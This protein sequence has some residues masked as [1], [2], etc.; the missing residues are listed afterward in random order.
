MDIV[1][2]LRGLKLERYV[3]AF[4][5]NDIDWTLLPRL[6]ADDLR[7]LGVVSIGHRRRLLEAIALLQSTESALEPSS[8]AS[9]EEDIER[10][11]VSVMFCDLVGSTPLSTLLDP[12]DLQR[13]IDAYHRCVAENVARFDGYLLRC[14]GDGVI[15][16]FGYPQAHEDDAERSVRS[17]LALLDAIGR[18][19]A[20][21]GLQ[22]R[23]GIASGTVVVRDPS[24]E[25]DASVRDIIGET[26]NLAARL[27]AAA[28]PNAIV[29]ADNTRIQIGEM[30][31][32]ADLGLLSL[33]G[34]AEPQRAWRVLGESGILSRFEALRSESMPLVGR[35]EELDLLLRRWQQSKSGE[36]RVVLLSGEPGIG[37][38]RMTAALSKA[39]RSEPHTRLRFFCS[40][41]HQDSAL[42]PLIMQLEHAAGWARDDTVERKIDKLRRVFSSRSDDEIALFADLMSLPSR[43]E[44]TNPNPQR[45]RE[46]LFEALL[47]EFQSLAAAAPVLMIFED[48][49]W[50]DPTSRELLDLVVDRIAGLRVLLVVTFRPEFQH[51]WA[52]QSH[53][54]TL[55]LNR[56]SGRNSRALVEKLVARDRGLQ[57][58]I[59]DEIVEHSDGVPLFVEE[60]T[61]T[62][63]E[64]DGRS[65]R[66]SSQLS[67]PASLHASLIERFDRLGSEARE[68]AQIGAVIGRDFVYDLL[69][70]VAQRPDDE[71]RTGLDRLA[72]AGLLFHRGVAP[73]SSYAFKHVLVRD[74]AYET[75]LRTRRRELHARVATALRQNFLDLIERQ[76]EILAYHLSE[77]GEVEAAVAQWILAGHYAAARSAH[78]EAIHHFDRGLALLTSLPAGPARDKCEIE[79]QLARGPSLFAAK[80]FAATEAA[81]AYARAC[82]LAEMHDNPRDL[83]AA[84]NGLWQSANGAGRVFECRRL[85]MRLQELTE[86]TGDDALRLQAHHS[87]WA[88]CLFSGEFVAARD[89]C[90]QGFRLYDPER[91]AL[92]HQLYGGHDPGACA[93]YLGAQVQWLLGYAEK[94]KSMCLEGL[95]VAE[96]SAHP[97]TVACALQYGSMLHLD[98]GEPAAALRQLE[99]ARMLAEE[100]QLGFVLDPMLLRGV[101]LTQMGELEEG[102]GCLRDGLASRIGAT[103]MRCYGLVALA[104]ALIRQGQFS[105]ALAAAREAISTVEQTGH[106]QWHAEAHR[107]EGMALVGLRRSED[108]EAALRQAVRVASGQGAKA[109]ELRATIALAQFCADHAQRPAARALLLPIY[110]YFSEGFETADLAGA[111][112]L[113]EQLA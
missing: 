72:Q 30:F 38:S 31:E 81:H 13:I 100:Q 7:E 22:L 25:A 76:P 89:H 11:L 59:V 63:L 103:R 1:D 41:Y 40:P 58:T 42:Y 32:L 28:Q 49:H 66:Q 92:Q 51:T 61:K 111:K 74:A 106:R 62:I 86:G 3:Q 64:K 109:Y 97:F 80:G 37:K 107:V 15:V 5:N 45:K 88:T 82:E 19:S 47:R 96:R 10:R 113:L 85:S 9:A 21:R 65:A 90:E 60:L 79:L 108:G 57:A 71:L 27:Q 110:N 75:L 33:K 43:S 84:V 52:G 68:V 77:A 87:A 98:R 70:R 102:L 2:W 24:D 39:V 46:N 29:I 73:Q 83:F 6:T 69:E 101:A 34:F 94:A 4:H 48:V 26:P 56:L 55:T 16:L 95:V 93:R 8:A 14:F 36:G 78:L 20:T 104:E 112:V 50:I 23:I 54:T 53:L 17:S 44:Q 35:D 91:H 12:E 105:P 67:I 18:I 99:T